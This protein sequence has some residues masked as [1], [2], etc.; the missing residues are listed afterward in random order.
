MKF[1]NPEDLCR[2]IELYAANGNSSQNK[3]YCSKEGDFFEKGTRPLTKR[4]QGELGKQ[5]Y[6]NLIDDAQN[7]RFKKIREENPRIF[8]SHISLIEK[9]ALRAPVKPEELDKL[10]N[11]WIYGSTKTGK[12]LSVKIKYWKQ[13]IY[14]KDPHSKW[15]DGYQGENIV[16]LDDL[17]AKKAKDYMGEFLKR[18]CGHEPFLA[19]TKGGGLGYI[20][21]RS[22]IVTSNWAINEIWSDEKQLEPIQRRF[23]QKHIVG[24]RDMV[25]LIQKYKFTKVFKCINSLRKYE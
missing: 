9:H 22:M 8:W 14:W 4:E 18:W 7:K 13:E 16:V 23:F 1:I 19:E 25:Q 5:F 24:A 6:E 15:W 21:P 11:F 12:T 3:D 10:D 20:R 17:D 2:G